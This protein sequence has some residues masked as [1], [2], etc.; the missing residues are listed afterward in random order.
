MHRIDFDA[1]HACPAQPNF[2]VIG[3]KINALTTTRGVTVVFERCPGPVERRE[4][5]QLGA[6]TVGGLCLPDLLAARES[7]GTTTHDTSVTVAALG[8]AVVARLSFVRQH[9][10]AT[11]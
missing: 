3:S 9:S 6:L 4:F 8:V 1:R 7:A 10:I 11:R 5:L 2:L